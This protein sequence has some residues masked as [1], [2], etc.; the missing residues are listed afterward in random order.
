MRSPLAQTD[1]E[2]AALAASIWAAC[3]IFA[4]PSLALAQAEAQ[5]QSR[6]VPAGEKRQLAFFTSVNPDCSVDGDFTVR[7]VKP[8]SHGDVEIEPGLGYT[9]YGRGD[10]RYRCNLA[11]EEGYR[12][13]YIS[14]S[15]YAGDDLF[16]IE[17]FSP[18]GHYRL[19]KYAL[20]VK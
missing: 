17:V 12:V 11:P 2:K 3:L 7:L 18:D 8:A 9:S 6:T 14:A 4:A 20:T 15:G 16:E 1:G 10:Q 5:I 13:N 19:W